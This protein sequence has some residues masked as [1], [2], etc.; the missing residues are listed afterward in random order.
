MDV[1]MNSTGAAHSHSNTATAD[2]EI[3]IML[4]PSRTQG[5][6]ISVNVTPCHDDDNNLQSEENAPYSGWE[7]TPPRH[8]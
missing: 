6:T 3:G 2:T 1:L 4:T 7:P 5:R 8:N